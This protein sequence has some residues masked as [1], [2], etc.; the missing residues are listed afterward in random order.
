ME[1]KDSK[2]MLQSTMYQLLRLD[3]FL[4]ALTQQMDILC[5]D[6][7]ST[8]DFSF[9]ASLRYSPKTGKFKIHLIS[10]YFQLFTPEERVA[11]LLH[12]IMHFSNGHIFDSIRNQDDDQKAR[13]R[14]IAAD[15][16]INQYIPHLP[17][18]C[19]DVSQWKDKEGK[20]FPLFRSSHEYMQL[21]EQIL[22]QGQ[23][24]GNVED[25]V[26]KYIPDHAFIE[27]GEGGEETNEKILKDG[28]GIIKRALD[29]ES[30]SFSQLPKSLQDLLQL[31]EAEVAKFNYKQVLQ[32]AVKRTLMSSDRSH[33]WKKPSKRHGIYSPGSK[34]EDLP[35]L[36]FFNDS[37][38]SVS[39][40]EQNTYLRI[41]DEFLKAGSRTC[42]LAFW[43]TGLYYKKPYKKGKEIMQSEIQSGGTDP[44]CVLKDIA[45][46]GYDLS[47]ILTDGCYDTCNVKVSS[48]V[49]WIISEGGALDHPLKHIGIT[50]PLSGLK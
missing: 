42:T 40:K 6:A 8:L 39:I 11:V 15:M 25:R 16:A 23:G 34:S 30:W 21:I 7:T 5:H 41:M 46:N 18:G 45:K 4:G 50:I 32:M 12:E 26:N 43:H 48:P 35:K 22:E 3:P 1:A 19:V 2:K 47:I 17:K 29:K 33:T 27:A 10:E 37:S 14:N 28:L 49:V 20:N 9:P 38:G 13:I 24:K 44:S 31:L 36:A